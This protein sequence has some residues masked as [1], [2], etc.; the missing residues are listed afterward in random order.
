MGYLTGRNAL[1]HALPPSVG[2]AIAEH[3][4]TVGKGVVGSCDGDAAHSADHALRGLPIT[5]GA[6]VVGRG[7]CGASLIS[8]MC[9]NS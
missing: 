5:L 3:V 1:R 2:A 9:A 8:K 6:S 7:R 4:E